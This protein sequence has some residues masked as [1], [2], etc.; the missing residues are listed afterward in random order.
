MIKIKFAFEDC[1]EIDGYEE[2]G[3]V[4][5]LLP[6]TKTWVVSHLESKQTVD[7]RIKFKLKDEA[8]LFVKD[9]LQTKIDWTQNR[10]DLR[11]SIN[12]DFDN[13]QNIVNKHFKKG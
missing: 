13:I 5:H 4:L 3:L 12:A 6:G 7:S 8:A 11:E 1:R 10:T 9:L 2:G